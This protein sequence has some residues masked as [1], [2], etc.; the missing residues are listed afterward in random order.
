MGTKTVRLINITTEPV[1]NKIEWFD[2]RKR[3]HCINYWSGTVDIS[4]SVYLNINTYTQIATNYSGIF[5]N[6]EETTLHRS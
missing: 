4:R 3:P 1:L 5:G 6:S 2:L